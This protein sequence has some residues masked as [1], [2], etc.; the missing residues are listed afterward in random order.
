MLSDHHKYFNL[1]AIFSFHI[2]DHLCILCLRDI[3]TGIKF[4]MHVYV[5]MQIYTLIQFCLHLSIHPSIHIDLFLSIYILAFNMYRLM[6]VSL[7]T[8]M[9]TYTYMHAHINTL[10]CMSPFIYTYIHMSRGCWVISVGTLRSQF[11]PEA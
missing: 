9:N 1:A 2:N 6:H 10:S 3:P 7:L 8:H 4:C 11:I 5:S